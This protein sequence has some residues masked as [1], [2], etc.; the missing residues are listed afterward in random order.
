MLKR[1]VKVFISSTFREMIEERNN[2]QQIVWRKLRFWAK[3]LG[4]HIIPIDLRWGISHDDIMDGKLALQCEEAIKDCSPYFV[5]ILG[6]TYGTDNPKVLGNIPHEYYGK[7]VTHYEIDKG[8]LEINNHKALIYNITYSKIKD[9]LFKRIKLNKLKKD[10]KSNYE[11]I[12]ISTR[13]RLNQ[14]IFN[15]LKTIIER[16]YGNDYSLSNI[17]KDAFFI[18]SNF[19]SQY[20][21]SFFDDE[22]MYKSLIDDK[23][24]V[25]YKSNEQDSV[26]TYLY[27]IY[28]FYRNKKIVFHDFSVTSYEKT[29]NG[30]FEHVIDSLDSNLIKR[31]EK[32]DDLKIEMYNL[33]KNINEPIHIIID[34]L[35]LIEKN[36]ADYIIQSFISFCPNNI[37]LYIG[38]YKNIEFFEN[39]YIKEIKELEISDAD[40]YIRCKL[41]EYKKD[42]NENLTN[43]IVNEL[44]QLGCY[45]ISYL[46][47]IL[48]EILMNGCSS[49]KII[50]EIKK[51]KNSNTLQK[52]FEKIIFDKNNTLSKNH[53]EECIS[54][55]YLLS[56]CYD[57]LYMKDIQDIMKN[58]NYN[59]FDI[60]DA[61]ELYGNWLS[62]CNG[63]YRI[64]YA[65]LKEVIKNYDKEL[66]EKYSYELYNYF[67]NDNSIHAIDEILN[68]YSKI[69][70]LD[71]SYKV[72]FS[73]DSF[74]N[75]VNNRYFK[76]TKLCK[77]NKKL[78]LEHIN[79]LWDESFKNSNMRICKEIINLTF[80][81]GYFDFLY[82]VLNQL[83]NTYPEQI[84]WKIKLAKYYREKGQYNNAVNIL[85]EVKDAVQNS[86]DVKTLIDI[87][88][89]LSYCYGKL[90]DFEYSN[91]YANISY[92]MRKANLKEFEKEMPV[93]LNSMAYSHFANGNYNEANKL[94]SESLN[95][96]IKYYGAEHPRV[97]N[98]MNNIAE[99]FL[100]Q[101]LYKEAKELLEKSNNIL[102]ET[103]G[104]NHLYTLVSKLNLYEC[105]IL[106]GEQI[107][108]N[109]MNK[110]NE[111]ENKLIPFVKGSDYEYS[112]YMIKAYCYW[113][114]ENIKEALDLAKKALSYFSKYIGNYC[115]ETN[116]L[117]KIISALQKEEL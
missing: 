5:A 91:K 50:D 2:I 37:K 30:F 35:D 11:V 82:K 60:I 44:L 79:R 70:D 101:G 20:Y 42:N 65:A 77:N 32:D 25:V 21:C 115:F 28:N 92:G 47:M 74:I 95:I 23:K 63:K 48:N 29:A 56:C 41:K 58:L 87:Y 39:I 49:E 99:I 85:N 7:S 86:F 27:H 43:N 76:V 62:F 9:S 100:R 84:E 24:I 64:R 40:K 1:V 114:L 94:Y 75:I 109:I 16:E 112:I 33:I 96:R 22:Y 8:I 31:L 59:E 88:D 51:Y 80:Y 10:L 104:E 89:Y 78:A 26:T 68:Y 102:Q 55:F 90:G 93:T 38:Y 81:L 116:F 6:N 67:R 53:N 19:Y 13:E 73:E 108:L 52:L 34:N 83:I 45:E 105:F 111:I 61:C 14:I 12:D 97:A 3:Q 71:S 107:N 110:L 57:Y 117:I 113:K 69:N 54:I 66:F 4:I 15:D 106:S 17:E 46:Q 72:I 18:D 98:N 36:E 103:L